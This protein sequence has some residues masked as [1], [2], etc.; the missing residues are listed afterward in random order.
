M[1]DIRHSS[2]RRSL[3]SDDTR[4][5]STAALAQVVVESRF[6][7][8]VSSPGGP[9]ASKVPAGLHRL[10]WLLAGTTPTKFFLTTA[11]TKTPGPSPLT[12]DSSTPP[13]LRDEK[14]GGRTTAAVQAG[15][16]TFTVC[17]NVEGAQWPFGVMSG[18]GGNRG[19]RSTFQALGRLSARLPVERRRFRPRPPDEVAI[20]DAFA[21]SDFA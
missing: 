15:R 8:N 7:G 6:G 21:R 11:C 1:P 16:G 20:G 3:R 17:T 10:P 4:A 5:A 9:G 13:S 18:R 19:A 2:R 12:D 14:V